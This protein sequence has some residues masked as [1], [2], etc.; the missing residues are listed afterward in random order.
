MEPVFIAGR[1]CGFFSELFSVLTGI[2]YA[3]RHNLMPVPHWCGQCLYW[4][5]KACNGWEQFFQPTYTGIDFESVPEQE[6]RFWGWRGPNGNINPLN[7]QRVR[8]LY[9]DNITLQPEVDEHVQRCMNS[10]NLE[11]TLGVHLRFTDKLPQHRSDIEAYVTHID[12]SIEHY[13]H[14]FVASD[15]QAALDHLKSRYGNRVQSLDV[16]RSEDG[17]GMTEGIHYCKHLDRPKLGLEALTDALVLS[18]CDM[19]IRTASNLGAFS[20]CLNPNM[21]NIDVCDFHGERWVN[22]KC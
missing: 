22:P 15:S 10:V 12:Q 3:R 16:Q 5:R 14:M 6:A 17:L 4:D 7:R 11:N 13:S 2:E 19:M 1:R 9:C 21:D 8:S 20:V 18:K